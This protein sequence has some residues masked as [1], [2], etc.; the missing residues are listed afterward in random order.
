MAVQWSFSFLQFIVWTFF[1]PG[2][3]KL[4]SFLA[5]KNRETPAK[6]FYDWKMILIKNGA[7]KLLFSE[8]YSSPSFSPPM[9]LF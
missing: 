7:T 4:N 9:S 3:G 2:T 8:E 5:L 1:N 6:R